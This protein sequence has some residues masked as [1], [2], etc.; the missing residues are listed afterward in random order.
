MN[1][2][3]FKSARFGVALAALFAFVGVFFFPS[4][5]ILENRLKAFLD[6]QGV[7]QTQLTLAEL[8]F[9]G[10][11]IRDVSWTDKDGAFRPVL[12]ELTARFSLFGLMFGRVKALEIVG[13]NLDA[14]EENGAWIFA[15][16]A[17]S[18]AG[19]TSK[20]LDFG[21]IPLGAARIE[22]SRFD[23][24]TKDWLAQG[25]FSLDW[26]KA[27]PSELRFLSDKV[28]IEAKGVK[29]ETGAVEAVL[30]VNPA[31]RAGEGTWSAKGIRLVGVDSGLPILQGA[32]AI[33]AER[34]RL[35]VSGTFAD[36]GGQTKVVFKFLLPMAG[37]EKKS[38][39]LKEASFPWN[40]GIL[41]TKNILWEAESGKDILV[42]VE[43]K[44]LSLDV[45]LEKTTGKKAVASGEVFGLLPFTIKP[46]GKII[47]RKGK[48]FAGDKGVIHLPPELLS[49]ENAQLAFARDVLKN[50]HYTRLEIEIDSAEDGRLVLA[51]KVEGQN[52]DL[53][54]GRPVNLNVRLSGDILDFA[55]QNVLLLTDPRN[56]LKQG[57][58]E[59]P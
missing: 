36:A 34:E 15:G 19:G 28:Q 37:G 33:L 59:K 6:G 20:G 30:R 41:S 49:G 22:K 57:G 58:H 3:T 14:R 1:I 46:D 23:V 35:A 54:L 21:A 25:G 31:L 16:K 13:L 10:A 51:L 56:Y 53:S 47:I 40:G 29:L 43:V 7:S 27:V 2:P 11:T 42:E 48:V 55:R 45:L 26:K 44:K 38:L 4:Q 24:K 52:P 17:I 39:F 32:G 18:D 12:S 8:G 9:G 50:L 5:E